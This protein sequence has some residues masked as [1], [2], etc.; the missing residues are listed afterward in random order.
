[1]NPAEI[2]LPASPVLNRTAGP[3]LEELMARNAELEHRNQQ[4]LA[5]GQ[6]LQNRF[7]NL[8]ERTRVEIL[9][10][11]NQRL[12]AELNGMRAAQDAAERNAEVQVRRPRII[13]PEKHNGK[14]TDYTRTF[15][16]A[17]RLA[18]QGRPEYE[19]DSEKV[20][21]FGLLLTEDAAKWFDPLITAPDEHRYLWNDFEAFVRSFKDAFGVH[22]AYDIAFDQMKILRQG[23]TPAATF[24]ARFKLLLTDLDY[25]EQQRMQQFQD[26]LRIEVQQHMVALDFENFEAM[27]S[28]AITIDQKLF[29]L[30]QSARTRNNQAPGNRPPAPAPPIPVPV[31]RAQPPVVPMDVDA[32]QRRNAAGN[33]TAE[34]RQRRMNLGLCL[35]CGLAGHLANACPLL[36]Q[37]RAR[38][39]AGNGEGQ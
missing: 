36:E 14:N 29:R 7:Q 16:N 9:E 38:E 11:R 30:E 15:V 34:E 26:K 20:R 6:D 31:P 28:R 39:P 19:Q 37:R 33:L 13:W 35:Y 24:A 18:I 8:E 12:E 32:V 5:Q 3:N 23:R 4:L 17:F 21:A 1:M 22:N 25:T 27:V 2:P 10:L